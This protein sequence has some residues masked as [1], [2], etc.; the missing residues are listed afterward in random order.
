MIVETLLP[1]APA[2]KK[3]LRN[4]LRRKGI[5][6]G[7]A[8]MVA[9]NDLYRV[10]PPGPDRRAIRALLMQSLVAEPAPEP[11]FKPKKLPTPPPPPP[12]EPEPVPEPI[13]EPP[14]PKKPA[15]K[16]QMM[17]LDLSDAAM[18]LQFGG[19]SDTDDDE[20]IVAAAAP[21]DPFAALAALSDSDAPNDGTSGFGS[22]YIGDR[23]NDTF[24][25][26]S[27]NVFGD[28][29][30]PF[31]DSDDTELAGSL[32]D[33]TGIADDPLDQLVV[34][35]VAAQLADTDGSGEADL[36]DFVAVPL[37]RPADSL[38]EPSAGE[39][40]GQPATTSQSG[41]ETVADEPAA[42][43][44]K[45]K[46]KK[47]KATDLASLSGNSALFDQLG[48]SFGDMGD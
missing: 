27:T 42:Q 13:P 12:P 29:F 30:D 9:L 5:D 15:K 41:P 10:T 44:P 43:A 22:D 25:S 21:E 26:A 2:Y 8:F 36:P 24:G 16:T 32:P 46:R 37:G 1:K 33:A 3:A 35:E 18:M 31:A 14:K 38:V 48:G 20:P 19:G 45:P 47:S 34:A 4:L 40:D 17:S 28:D 7:P 6:F 23:E 11:E 39:P